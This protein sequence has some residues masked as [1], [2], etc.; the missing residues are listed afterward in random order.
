MRPFVLIALLASLCAPAAA[1]AHSVDVAALQVA[2]KARGL[3]SGSVDGVAGPGTRAGVVSFQRAAG[4]VADGIAGP[5]T[6][7]ALG[8]LGRP[9]LGTRTLAAPSRGWDVSS[10]QWLLARHGFPSGPFDGALGP[11]TGAAIGRFQA[12]HGLA[13]D[14]VAGPV[15][16]RAVRGAPPRSLL[17]FRAPIAA[18]IGSYFGPRGS[19][20]HTGLDYTAS[21]GAA[22]YAAG[23][24]CA[25][26]AGWDS[27][28]YG[29]TVA[30]RHRLGMVSM[31]AHLS[32]ITVRHGE[33]VVAGERIGLVGSTGNSAGPHLHFELRL[34]G[35]AVDPLTGL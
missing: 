26:F 11:R 8:V 3:Y 20:F 35:G 9:S 22:V 23:Y 21:S 32:A 34:N 4:L 2:L 27:G 13:S 10:L 16:I 30:I 5:A 14:Q 31:Y 24:G 12:A 15:T 7:A 29:N 17:R 1:G 18:P 25:S 19:G 6:R 33:C 28:G